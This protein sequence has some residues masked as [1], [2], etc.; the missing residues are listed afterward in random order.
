MKFFLCG[1]GFSSRAPVVDVMVDV[2]IGAH[3]H[4]EP[5]QVGDD[6]GFVQHSDGGKFLFF[7]SFKNKLRMNSFF[8]VD[9]SVTNP[10]LTKKSLFFG[11]TTQF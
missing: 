10:F 5:P 2:G 4:E 6:N 11:N 1:V 3:P 8:L 9:P 7:L